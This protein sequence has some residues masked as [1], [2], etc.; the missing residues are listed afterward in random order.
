MIDKVFGAPSGFLLRILAYPGP[1]LST[2]VSLA[3]ED[4]APLKAYPGFLNKWSNWAVGRSNWPPRPPVWETL[5][6]AFSWM[7][8]SLPKTVPL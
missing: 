5:A 1:G 7:S 4:G 8:F 3:F 2:T 6:L